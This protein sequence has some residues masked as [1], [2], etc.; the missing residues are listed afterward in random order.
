MACTI[1]VALEVAKEAGG[2]AAGC[3]SGGGAT[4]GEALPLVL[5]TSMADSALEGA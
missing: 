4:R 2:A 3:F 1:L 5:I